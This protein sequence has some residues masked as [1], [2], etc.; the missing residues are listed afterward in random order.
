MAKQNTNPLS[1]HF[2][3]PKKYTRLP[4][5]GRYYSEQVVEMPDSE[6][7]PIFPM[8]AKDELIMRNPDALLNGEAV[9]QVIQSCVPNVKNARKLLSNDVDALLLAIQGASY[10][11]DVEIKATCPDCKEEVTGSISADA[12]L[13]SMGI[14][15][16]AYTFDVDDLKI[17]IRPFTYETT[18]EAGLTNFQSTRSL[19]AMAEM[20]DDLDKLKL[21]NESFIKMAQLN[22]SIM[23]EVVE[24]IT[25]EGD[26]GE[27]IAVHDKK[28]IKEFLENCESNIG[29]EIESRINDVAGVGVAKEGE[30]ECEKCEKT[31][32]AG[33]SYDP[34]NFSMAS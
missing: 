22:F 25:V 6:E 30:F 26:D 24:S 13:Q 7:L 16:D 1:G 20:P 27:P 9:S 34:V 10:G 3:S 14:L 28:Q 23:V 12:V 31:F 17:E 18:I 4:S 5:A 15:E 11:D 29:R 21:F 19:Q 32:T 2:R 8:T 33:V